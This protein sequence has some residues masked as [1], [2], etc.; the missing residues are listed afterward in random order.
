[1]PDIEDTEGNESYS[2]IFSCYEGESDQCMD[3]YFYGVT[4]GG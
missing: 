4:I 3:K 2:I 1:M